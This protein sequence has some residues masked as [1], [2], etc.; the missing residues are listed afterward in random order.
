MPKTVMV[1]EDYADAREMMKILIQSHGYLVIEAVDGS[2][3]VEKSAEFHPDLIFMDLAM[4]IMDGATATKRIRET[5]GNDKVSIIALTGYGNASFEKA[6][7]EGFD[8][9]LVKPLYIETLEPLL[10]YYLA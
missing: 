3:A 5:E 1:V 7:E 8:A 4:P 2:D 6:R 9:L 10:N